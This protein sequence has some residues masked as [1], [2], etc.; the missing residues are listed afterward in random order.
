MLNITLAEFPKWRFNSEQENSQL[1]TTNT[2][3]NDQPNPKPVIKEHSANVRESSSK[4]KT[5]I[6]GSNSKQSTTSTTPAFSSETTPT[7]KTSLIPERILKKDVFNDITV[8]AVLNAD[9]D[10]QVTV[11]QLKTAYNEARHALMGRY[12]ESRQQLPPGNRELL[13]Q[14]ER[15]LAEKLEVVERAYRSVCKL[16]GY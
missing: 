15:L 7:R 2:T 14:L 5:V 10:Q 8:S 1:N 16:R 12:N 9:H 6:G 3:I 11:E 13:S 4:K